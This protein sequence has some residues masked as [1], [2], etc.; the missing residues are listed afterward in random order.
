MALAAGRDHELVHDAAL[1]ADPAVLGALGQARGGDGLPRQAGGGGEGARGRDLE[2]GRRGQAGADRDLARQHALPAA[3]AWARLLEGPGRAFHV[4]DPALA[5]LE[6]PQVELVLVAEIQRAQHDPAVRA[7]TQRD[8]GPEVQGHG[9]HEPFVVVGVLAEQVHPP[10]RVDD[11]RRVAAEALGEGRARPGARPSRPHLARGEL[12]G[13]TGAHR[14]RR[15][16]DVRR[17][18]STPVMRCATASSLASARASSPTTRPL[19]STTIRVERA[20]SSGIS[21]EI[22]RTR[23][24]VARPGGR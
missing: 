13:G 24:A 14:V 23:A 18:T 8:P 21:L 17:G 1:H 2:R 15:D 5:A 6:A 20:S 7:R 11:Q 4:F 12:T 16:L 22:R 19:R 10:G 3:Q 9:Q